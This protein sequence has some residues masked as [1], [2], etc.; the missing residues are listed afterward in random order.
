[1]K[2]KVILTERVA[3]EGLTEKRGV[4]YD[5]SSLRRRKKFVS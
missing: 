1:L 3:R 2:K 5:E 4:P